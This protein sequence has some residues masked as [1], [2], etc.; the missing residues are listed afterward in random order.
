MTT[1]AVQGSHW[2]RKWQQ[3]HPHFCASRRHL[4]SPLCRCS[5]RTRCET[6]IWTRT[7]AEGLGSDCVPNA[8]AVHRFQSTWAL[9]A[10]HG[11]K[12]LP[13]IIL[14][15]RQFEVGTSQA[16]RIVKAYLCE[17]STT[18]EKSRG[19]LRCH[20]QRAPK[21]GEETDAFTASAAI[22][23]NEEHTKSMSAAESQAS[24]EVTH[25]RLPRRNDSE[26]RYHPKGM[27]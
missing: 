8:C 1:T 19:K 20:R 9:H 11:I 24:G 25:V 26:S 2:G 7:S 16:R 4:C 17:L 5:A 27:P 3:Q 23:V 13:F 6:G 15:F 21:G 18:G 12:I 22:E 14:G 10:G